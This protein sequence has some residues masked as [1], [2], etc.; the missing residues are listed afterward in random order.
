MKIYKKLYIIR[1][2]L[3]NMEAMKL[4]LIVWLKIMPLVGL[5]PIKILIIQNRSKLKLY[6][7]LDSFK[8]CLVIKRFKLHKWKFRE[9]YKDF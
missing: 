5:I 4:E 3:P 7:C 6:K 9:F 2:N 1:L 8:G